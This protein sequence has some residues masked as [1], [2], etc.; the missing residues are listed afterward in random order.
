MPRTLT[1]LFVMLRLL[2]IIALAGAAIPAGAGAARALGAH[3]W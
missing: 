1:A 2:V 3:R